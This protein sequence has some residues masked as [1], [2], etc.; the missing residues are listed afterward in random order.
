MKWK[1]KNRT[2][3]REKWDKPMSTTRKELDRIVLLFLDVLTLQITPIYWRIGI[4]KM[5]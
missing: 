5:R 4:G 1:I 2:E 3:E